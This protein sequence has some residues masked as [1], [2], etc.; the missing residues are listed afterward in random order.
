[1]PA[2]WSAGSRSGMTT[3]SRSRATAA[4]ESALNTT[5]TS[6]LAPGAISPS[7]GSST[8]GP[9]ASWC[10]AAAG[11]EPF[12]SAA[13]VMGR[14]GGRP[15]EGKHLDSSS[16][17]QQGQGSSTMAAAWRGCT[18][19]STQRTLLAAGGRRA[20]AGGGAGG[21]PRRGGARCC[22]LLQLR[23]AWPLVRLL[24]PEAQGELAQVGDLER[25]GRGG[26][27]EG[28]WEGQL[29]FWAGG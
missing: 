3:S 22:R 19:S 18:S 6:C 21:A 29:S 16:G 12:L 25:P 28:R 7:A 23:R 5:L 20:L 2:G 27:G 14:R 17:T 15:G 8:K 26:V 4:A 10:T 13:Q 1:M 9:S 11:V 24:Q